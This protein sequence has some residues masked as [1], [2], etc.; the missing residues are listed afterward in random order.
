[1]S[2]GSDASGFEYMASYDKLVC[3]N[4]NWVTDTFQAATPACTA[5]P[6]KAIYQSSLVQNGEIDCS[7]SAIIDDGIRAKCKIIPVIFHF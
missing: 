2:C 1:M 5:K 4:H 6:C 3:H 7:P